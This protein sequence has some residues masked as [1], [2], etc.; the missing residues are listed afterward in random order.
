MARLLSTGDI[1][2]MRGRMNSMLPD[3]ATIERATSTKVRGEVTQTWKPIARSIACR[4]API[5]GGETGRV[6]GRIS[7]RTT[8]LV[9]VAAATDIEEADRITV[10]GSP[11]EV[12]LVRKR[13]SWEL[14]RRVEVREL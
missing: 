12:T 5:G 1:A 8:H 9:T 10:N 13:G 4:I 14:S 6:A 11:F 3:T 7:E 2:A